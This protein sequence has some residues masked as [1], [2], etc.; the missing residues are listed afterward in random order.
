[1]ALPGEVPTE[2]FPIVEEV[3]TIPTLLLGT[4]GRDMV[5]GLGMFGVVVCCVFRCCCCCCCCWIGVVL[6]LVVVLAVVLA[7]VWPAGLVI[8][9]LA[10]DLA[11]SCAA[12]IRNCSRR[13]C[14]LLA[15]FV[16]V[17]VFVFVLLVRLMAEPVRCGGSRV[18]ATMLLRNEFVLLLVLLRLRFVPLAPLL[19]FRIME[20][21]SIVSAATMNYRNE[22]SVQC[23][24][25]N[26]VRARLL[27]GKRLG[28][29]SCWWIV[30]WDIETVGWLMVNG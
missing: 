3:G 23:A 25:C 4:S 8:A 27:V 7:V 22:W 21:G 10:E 17:F 19:A 30:S 9:G 5:C 1:M 29:S 11:W 20:G 15:L 6:V 26:V 14:W 2:R 12:I 16:F 18:P 24:M 13:W 28:S